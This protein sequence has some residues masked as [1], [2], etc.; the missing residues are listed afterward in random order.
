MLYILTFLWGML[1]GK[2]FSS[3]K[4]GSAKIEPLEPWPDPPNEKWTFNECGM[5]VV[6]QAWI[7]NHVTMPKCKPPKGEND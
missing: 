6:P 5:P 4:G 3:R 2:W 7:D 1:F